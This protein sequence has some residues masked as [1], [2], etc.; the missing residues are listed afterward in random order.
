MHPLIKLIEKDSRLVVG[1]MSG[2]SA[3][4]VDVAFCRISGYGLSSKIEQVGFYFEPFSDEVREKILYLATG[5]EA[6]AEEFCKANFLFGYLYVRAVKN[7]CAK[8]GFK[9]EDIDLIGSHGQTLWHVP[10]EEYY[11]GN[12]FKST[13]QLGEFSLLAEEFDCPVVG[14]F[15]VRDVAAGGFGAPLVPYSEF[16]IYRS[17]SECIALQ[18]IGGIGNITCLEPNCKM[19]DVFA[20]D[21][22]AGNM[23]MDAIYFE[24][25]GGKHSYDKGGDFASAGTVDEQMLEFLMEDEYVRTAPPKTTGRE[26]YGAKYVEKILKY[27]GEHRI[28]DRDLM[29]TVTAFTAKSIAYSVDNYFRVK[30][31]KLIIG[32][33]G[34]R[35]Q[36]LVS[37]IRKFLPDTKVLLN[38]DLGF[39][40]EAKEAVAF[41]VLANETIFASP[42][43]VASV[44]GARHPVVMGKITF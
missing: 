28:N 13:L 24:V 39:D 3:D 30:P 40:S 43:N 33:G 10:V 6:S 8:L 37:Y 19:E 36:T 38:E 27:A 32:G 7:A 29:A 11:L 42:N 21:T 12:N 34:S 1:I 4:G 26:Y 5:N 25:T 44:T 35:N 14:D 41:A 23:L 15:R 20:F 18:N 31:D 16:L 22:G 2:T 9:S 17:E